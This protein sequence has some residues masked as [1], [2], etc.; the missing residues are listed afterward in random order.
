VNILVSLFAAALALAALVLLALVVF[1]F[2]VASR[3]TRALP[4][5][6]GFVDL[7]SARL[8]YVEKGEGPAI[9]MIH[10]LGGQTG[11]FEHSLVERLSDT[12]RVVLVDRPGSGHST[13]RPGEAVS[14]PAQAAA[15]AALIERLGLERPLVVGHS[16]GGG[17]ALA[18]ALDHP[19]AVGGLALL[20][21]LT[22]MPDEVPKALGK[23]ALRSPLARRLV[24]W[25]IA[26][27]LG[28]RGG[29]RTLDMVFAPDV[30]P[31]DFGLKAGGLM[32]LRPA[33]FVSAS[34]D[35]VAL[36]AELPRL[37]ARYEE[38][39]V[40]VAILFG[41]GDTILDPELH[42][43]RMLAAHPATRLDLVEGGHMLLVSQPDLVADWIRGCAARLAGEPATQ[44]LEVGTQR[45]EAAGTSP[46]DLLERSAS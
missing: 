23:L 43:R 44:R 6:G 25:T 37:M 19:R 22:H 10:G 9:V 42:G 14:L 13:R 1:T 12:F 8:H 7:G 15:I 41:R 32:A 20:S 24:A 33:S 34:A 29:R 35:L 16:L 28:L 40:P 39:A 30:P 27:P 2:V 36:E 31:E 46:L 17:V 26:T 45:S 5:R 38:L 4:P 21:P 3:V 11:N 18:L